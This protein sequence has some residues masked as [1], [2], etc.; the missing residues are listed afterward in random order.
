MGLGLRLSLGCGVSRLPWFTL[1]KADGIDPSLWADFANNRYAVNGSLKAFSDIFT[2]TRSTT[3]TYF[4]SSGVMQTA[5]IN[6]PRLDYNPLTGSALGLLLEEQR[7]NLLIQTMSFSS[8]WNFYRSTT[9]TDGAVA[10]PTG[11]LGVLKLTPQDA[12]SNANQSISVTTG[13]TYVVS[14]YAKAVSGT[15]NVRAGIYNGISA[16]AGSDFAINSTT[17]TRVYYIFTAT[18]TASYQMQLRNG[19]AGDTDAFYVWGAQAEVGAFASS[20]IPTTTVAVTRTA[21]T[22][23]ATSAN[24]VPSTSWINASEGT[25]YANHTRFTDQPSTN[26]AMFALDNGTTSDYVSLNGPAD[27]R[28]RLSVVAASVTQANIDSGS[29]SPTPLKATGSY[30]VNDFELVANGVSKGTDTLGT[31]PTLTQFRSASAKTITGYLKEI[32]YYPIRVTS[33]EQQRITA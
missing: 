7:T 32:R 24:T 21:D 29:T 19:S 31:V 20:Y 2:F 8:G 15:K 3:G 10:A 5:A 22:F 17:W 18:S 4:D 30:K 13:V 14:F 27:G 9:S 28:L 23:V 16:I 25:C 6:A 11:D 26:V 1:G 33:T 12:L